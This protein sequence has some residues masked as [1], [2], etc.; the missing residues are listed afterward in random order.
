MVEE[1]VPAVY[2]VLAPAPSTKVHPAAVFAA[3][4]PVPVGTRQSK[5]WV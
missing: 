2:V 4:V 5:S 1:P 3:S